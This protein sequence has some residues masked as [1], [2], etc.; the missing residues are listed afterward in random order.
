MNT[1]GTLIREK[2]RTRGLTQADLA[3]DVGIT[4]GYLAKIETD[5]QSAGLK[6]LIAI[7]DVLQIPEE[8]I[9]AQSITSL[10]VI[11]AVKKMRQY[12]LEFSKLT[13]KVKRFLL[14]LAPILEKYL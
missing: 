6:T 9:L 12:E 7:A 8:D 13:P 1:I 14:E 3:D 11:E 4:P 2:R 10:P 5:F